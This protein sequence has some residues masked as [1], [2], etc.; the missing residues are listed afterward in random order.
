[1]IDFAMNTPWKVILA[2]A[3]V[4]VAGAIF[5]GPFA[6][7]IK[8]LRQN[9]RP[10]FAERTMARFEKEFELTEAQKEKIMPILVRAQKDW[11]QLRHD[12]VRNLTAL[13]DRMHLELSA[14]LTPDQQKKL[15]GISKEFRSRAERFR[16]R[17]LD[18]ERRRD[19]GGPSH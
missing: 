8:E 2:F 18:Q 3:G 12:N 11:R 13:V 16:G 14:E 7:W 1:L 19:A 15:E 17:V 4:F 10:P 6:D 5:G 9:N